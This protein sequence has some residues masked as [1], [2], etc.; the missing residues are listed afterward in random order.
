MKIISTETSKSVLNGLKGIYCNFGLPHKISS[1]N[2]PCF[3]SAEFKE[4]YEKLGIITETSSTCKHI[5][6]GSVECIFQTVKKIMTKNPDN[7]WLTMLIFRATPIPD[8]YK[9]PAELLNAK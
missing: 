8:I 6:G 1:D 9:S 7:T 2:G 5:S 4:F 3:K